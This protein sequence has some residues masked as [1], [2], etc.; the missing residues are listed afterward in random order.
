MRK[1]AKEAVKSVNQSIRDQVKTEQEAVVKKL[2]SRKVK[3][4]Q[5]EEYVA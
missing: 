5:T 2:A 1:L 4:S 3:R